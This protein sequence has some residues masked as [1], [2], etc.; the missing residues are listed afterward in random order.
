LLSV[1]VR[2]PILIDLRADVEPAPPVRPALTIDGDKPLVD[3]RLK[4]H[5]RC[6]L[7]DRRRFTLK[8]IRHRRGGWKHDLGRDLN[9]LSSI[10]IPEYH[11]FAGAMAQ[12][13]RKGNRSINMVT[14]YR[15]GREEDV[16]G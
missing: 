16:G 8:A 15:H 4:C 10:V 9:R 13:E 5:A 14:R 7:Y 12:L 3:A 11:W 2:G 1:R 6:D